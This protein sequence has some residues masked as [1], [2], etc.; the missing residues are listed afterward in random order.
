V[1]EHR[2]QPALD[3]GPPSVHD[4]QQGDGAG[5]WSWGGARRR[6]Q[7]LELAP[8]GAVHDFPPTFAQSL[9]NRIGF[10]EVLGS[11]AGYSFSE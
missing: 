11:S 1:R 7:R 8:V 5:D 4:R 9:A 6:L 2:Q 10:C 3:V